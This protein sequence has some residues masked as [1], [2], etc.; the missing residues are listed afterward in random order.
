MIRGTWK[1]R[2]IK[3]CVT[4]WLH[5]SIRWQFT[6][7]ERGVWAD[8]LAWAGE[9]QKSG[10][11]C[12]NDGRPLPRDFMANALNIKQELLG[13][14]I[15]K[16]IHEGRLEDKEGVLFVTNY[17][18]YQSEYERQ[19]PYRQQ[20]GEDSQSDDILD[21]NLAAI[22]KCYEDNIGILTPILADQLQDIS[23]TYPE[24]WFEKAVAIACEKNA[25]NLKYISKILQ[26][27]LVEGVDSEPGG[28]SKHERIQKYTDD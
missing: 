6:S 19:K 5:G 9:I 8:L 18:A 7:E 27:W 26:R 28:L 3:L 23:D 13:R 11:I 17:E 10:A 25:R 24:G 16:C 1:R 21:A 14:V 22:H 20:P 15:A 4:G 12:D 2:W